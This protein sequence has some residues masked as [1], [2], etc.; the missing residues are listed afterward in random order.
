ML[1]K[2]LIGGVNY[3]LTDSIYIQWSFFNTI[4]LSKDQSTL[5]V[6]EWD[7]SRRRFHSLDASTCLR[8]EIEI[9]TQALGRNVCQTFTAFPT[10]CGRGASLPFLTVDQTCMDQWNIGGHD[11]VPDLSLGSKQHGNFP[12]VLCHPP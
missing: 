6:A 11:S 1:F 9:C 7:S 10:H 12:P 2:A 3:Y 4:C 5:T 8:G